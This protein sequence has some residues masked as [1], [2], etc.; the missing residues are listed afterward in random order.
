MSDFVHPPELSLFAEPWLTQGV[1]KVQSV[2]YRPVAQLNDL[3]VIDFH[4]PGT[5]SQYLDMHNLRLHMKLQILKPDGRPIDGTDSVGFVAT[6][7]HSMF[8]QID[9]FLQQENISSS[10]NLYAYKAYTEKLLNTCTTTGHPQSEAELYILDGTSTFLKPNNMDQAD[11]DPMME[12]PAGKFI[13]NESAQNKGLYKRA[14]HT[15]L[16][17]TIDLEGGLHCDICQQ[18]RYIL[19]SVDMRVRLFPSQNAFRLMTDSGNHYQVKIADIYLRVQKITVS[20]EVILAH[21]E[22]LESKPAIY[23]YYKS[24]L[25]TFTIPKGQYSHSIDDLFSGKIP[26][27]LYVWFVSAAAFNGDYSRNPFNYQHYGIRTAG[28]YVDGQSV[29]NQPLQL[30]FT[31]RDVVTGYTALLDTASK[32]HPNSEFDIDI[33]RFTDGYTILAF[34]L[35]STTTD[36][37]YYWVRPTIAHSRLELRFSAPLP[38][39]VNVI[40]LGVYPQILY[41]DKARNVTT[42]TQ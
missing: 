35:E 9:I 27:K 32:S 29:P 11:P 15:S 41:I 38:E 24:D 2:D 17:R 30:D 39:A 40:M 26:S 6:P 25:K 3:T 20:P 22:T 31:H 5:G 37:L 19:N 14:L 18:E 42:S 4:V 12:K 13:K 8:S 23:P 21:N 16:G 1:S 36:S 34:N 28:F 33:K 10:T 7:L